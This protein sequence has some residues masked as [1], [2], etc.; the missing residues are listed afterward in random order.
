MY[1]NQL[2]IPSKCLLLAD[3]LTYLGLVDSWAEKVDSYLRSMFQETQERD[4]PGCPVGKTLRSQCRWPR[5]DPWL[6][7]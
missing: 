1:I 5:F 2:L 4:F 6:G 3:H 7:N